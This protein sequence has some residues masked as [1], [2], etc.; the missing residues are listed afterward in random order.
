M[1]VILQGDCVTEMKKLLDESIHMIFADPPYNLQ[2]GNKTLKRPN[3]STVHGVTEGWD[4][5]SSFEEYDQFTLQ[6]LSECSRLLKKNGTIW[7]SG[8]Y[9]N[10]FRIGTL[11]MNLGFWVLN[12]ILWIKA[13]PMPN[14]AG[15]RFTNASE[16]IIWA[17]KSKDATHITFNYQLLKKLNG[18]KQMRNDWYIPICSGKERLRNSQGNKEH[19]T[20][21]PIALLKRIILASTQTQDIILDPFGGTGTTALVAKMLNRQFITIEQNE[22]YVNLIKERLHSLPDL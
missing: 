1:E 18:G 10:I 4:Q 21:K 8:T 12:D 15:Q 7:V 11:M 5:F 3:D 16:T 14:F 2:L 20:Q 17:K 22:K 9:H 13:N 19:S 6:W